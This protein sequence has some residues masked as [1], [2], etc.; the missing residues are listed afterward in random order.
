MRENL[1]KGV[2]YVVLLNMDILIDDSNV[3]SELVKWRI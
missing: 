1:G 3:I 2:K